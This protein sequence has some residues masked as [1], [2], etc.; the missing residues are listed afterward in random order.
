M[1]LNKIII[2]G[3]IVGVACISTFR[4][5]K[6]VY[7]YYTYEGVYGR[8]DKCESNHDVRCEIDG[9]MVLVSQ[10]SLIDKK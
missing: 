7:E 2:G 8:S 4:I 3:I 10:Y 5:E 9:R 6:G 1:N